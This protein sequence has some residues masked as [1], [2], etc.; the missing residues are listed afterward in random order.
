MNWMTTLEINPLSVALSANIFSHSEN[1]LFILF[2]VSFVV[3]KLFSLGGRSKKSLLWL[4]QL[5]LF[6]C[7]PLRVL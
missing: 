4:C 1:C 7:F 3:Q 5:M 2:T 6:L